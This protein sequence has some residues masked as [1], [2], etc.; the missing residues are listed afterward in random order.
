MTTQQSLP[1][2][3]REL[4]TTIVDGLIAEHPDAAAAFRPVFEGSPDTAEQW[5]VHQLAEVAPADVTPPEEIAVAVEPVE[6]SPADQ[7]VEKTLDAVYERIV[8]DDLLD[9]LAEL[10]PEE[11]EQHWQEALRELAAEGSE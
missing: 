9:E 7:A 3:I 1:D 10:T 8:A 4:T 6:L 2:D 11:L 5:I